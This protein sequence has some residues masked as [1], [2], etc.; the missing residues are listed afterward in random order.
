MS[1]HSPSLLTLGVY[2]PVRPRQPVQGRCIRATDS[3]QA[4]ASPRQFGSRLAQDM[5]QV[6]CLA[7]RTIRP[8]QSMLCQILSRCSRTA[9]AGRNARAPHIQCSPVCSGAGYA[10]RFP[11]D[12]SQKAKL[13]RSAG[14][15]GHQ[16]MVFEFAASGG[17]RCS[18][19]QCSTTLPSLSRRKMSMPAHS[20]SFGQSW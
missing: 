14:V 11:R 17:I 18:T 12:A 9:A 3:R 10:I 5:M 19:S 16:N 1:A 4:L 20:P 6:D 13:Y 2:S 15:G 7:T 8:P